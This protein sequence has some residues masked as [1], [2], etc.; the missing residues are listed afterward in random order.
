MT[1]EYRARLEKYLSSMMQ[2]KQMLSQ[3]IINPDDYVKIDTILAAKYG[4]ESCNL[5]RG[6]DLIYSEVGG[7]MSHYGEVMTCL[8]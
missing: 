4:F 6:V 3:G 7:N 5:Y 8:K 1:K 2:A